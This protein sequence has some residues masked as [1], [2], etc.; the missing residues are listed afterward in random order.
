MNTVE[1][2]KALCKATNTPISKLEKS[3][4]FSNGYIGKLQKG[5]VP[6]DRLLSISEYFNVS[7][8]YLIT[9][10]DEEF[11]AEIS[12]LDAGLRCQDER[13]KEYML[14][15]ARL[16]EKKREYIILLIDDLSK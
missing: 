7:V 10:K 14:K 3:L 5:V 8:D 4:G 6:G 12:D 16:E 9:G 13:I 15:F 2:I 11:P 1:R